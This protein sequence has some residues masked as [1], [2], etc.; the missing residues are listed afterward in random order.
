MLAA[1][2]EELTNT[3]EFKKKKSLI[4]SSSGTSEQ[5]QRV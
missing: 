1:L 4:A 5:Q 2:V 3:P